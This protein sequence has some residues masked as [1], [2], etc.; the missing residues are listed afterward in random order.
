MLCL[1]LIYLCI[2]FKTFT[3]SLLL[4]ILCFSNDI[5]SLYDFCMTFVY[6]YAICKRIILEQH[7]C[8]TFATLT[9]SN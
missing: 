3:G 5:L 2:K 1:F 6:F 9:I 4:S 8:D 7:E